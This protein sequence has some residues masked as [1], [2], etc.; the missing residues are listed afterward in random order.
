[1]PVPKAGNGE[2]VIT[3]KAA[4]LCHSDVSFIDGTITYLLK[5]IPIVLGHEIAG[6]VSEVGEGV[7]DFKIGQRVGVP[8]TTDGPGTATNGGFADS[9]VV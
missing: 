5:E 9:V 4:G 3:I 6:L 1:M 2:I 7:D 8:A